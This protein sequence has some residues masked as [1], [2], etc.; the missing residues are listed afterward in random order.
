[1][2][3]ETTRRTRRLAR[4]AQTRRGVGSLTAALPLWTLPYAVM[5][6]PWVY[7]IQGVYDVPTSAF[8]VTFA[9]L[10]PFAAVLFLLGPLTR[11]QRARLRV[12]LGVAI[13]DAEAPRFTWTRTGGAR[14]ALQAEA[15]WRQAYYHFIVGPLVGLGYLTAATVVAGWFAALSLVGWV[16]VQPLPGAGGPGR[17]VFWAGFVPVL[18]GLPFLLLVPRA[19]RALSRADTEAA[20]RLLGPSRTVELIRRVDALA[21]GRA[22]A[23]DAADAE[24]RRIERDLHDGAQQRLVALAMDLGMAKAKLK[25]GDAGNDDH[26]AAA[27]LVAEAHEGVKLALSELRDLARGI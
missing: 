25:N 4:R 22:A 16:V 24:R 6:V 20:G 5:A 21:A 9:I 19:V 8:A 7:T 18:V 3:V 27:K 17:E 1:M 23:V 26:A 12:V 10:I 13:A 14:E 11:W 2:T 15:T